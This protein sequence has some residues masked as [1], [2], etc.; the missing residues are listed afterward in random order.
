MRY[1]VF[2]PSVARIRP[3]TRIILPLLKLGERPVFHM[4]SPCML[5]HTRP[6]RRLLAPY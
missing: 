5:M 3:S 2:S 4:I 1:K 6:S